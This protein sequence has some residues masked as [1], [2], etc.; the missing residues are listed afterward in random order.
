[1]SV[2]QCNK[3]EMQTMCD[4]FTE[5]KE[6]VHKITKKELEDD[7]RWKQ[8]MIETDFYTSIMLGNEFATGRQNT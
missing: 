2:L 4:D 1:M 5:N 3:C 6:C 8:R 7:I